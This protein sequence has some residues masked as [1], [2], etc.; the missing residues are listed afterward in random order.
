M[1]Q[2]AI[3]AEEGDERT[4]G[5]PRWFVALV[6]AGTLSIVLVMTAFVAKGLYVDW[7]WFESLGLGSVFLTI[8]WTGLWLFLLVAGTTSALLL[9]NLFL[10]RALARRRWRGILRALPTMEEESEEDRRPRR[11]RP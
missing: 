4:Q 7:L 11:S 10:A 2:P 3:G 8:T 6:L 9:G 1:I 5:G